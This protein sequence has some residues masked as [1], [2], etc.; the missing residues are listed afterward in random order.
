MKT[1]CRSRGRCGDCGQEWRVLWELRAELYHKQNISENVDRSRTGR[2][3]LV[4]THK[5][6]PLNSLVL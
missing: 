5:I 3:V 1:A 4:F 6:F 2:D